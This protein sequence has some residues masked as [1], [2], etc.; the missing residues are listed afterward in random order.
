MLRAQGIAAYV[1]DSAGKISNYI[2]LSI[3]LMV[4]G[5]HLKTSFLCALNVIVIWAKLIHT[6]QKVETIHQ[7][8]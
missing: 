5:T 3:N 4:D 2:T 8:N 1:I 6:I 7:M